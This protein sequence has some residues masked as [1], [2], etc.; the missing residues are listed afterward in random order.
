MSVL[1]SVVGCAP[2]TIKDLCN[3]RIPKT[4]QKL[5]DAEKWLKGWRAEEGLDRAIATEVEPQAQIQPVLPEDLR[6][7]WQ[8]WSRDQL[9]EVQRQMDIVS[10]DPT[11]REQREQMMGVADELVI[12]YGYAG[13]GDSERMLKKIKAVREKKM[14]VRGD[15]C[16]EEVWRK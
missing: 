15:L 2:P 10:L 11:L 9:V 16:R 5:A 12:L 8:N 3:D 6:S 7:Q 1:W 14:L 13:L 4:N